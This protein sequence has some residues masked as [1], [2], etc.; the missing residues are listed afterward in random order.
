MNIEIILNELQ[1]VIDKLKVKLLFL[2]TE[3]KELKKKIN[4]LNQ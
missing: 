2:K 3:N 1:E 4:E